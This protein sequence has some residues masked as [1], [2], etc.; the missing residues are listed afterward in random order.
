MKRLAP[1][2][3]AALVALAGCD[4]TGPETPTA[5]GNVAPWPT[6]QGLVTIALILERSQPH[7]DGQVQGTFRLDSAAGTR[8][9]PFTWDTRDAPIET[10]GDQRFH[11]VDPIACDPAEGPVTV[12]VEMG[13]WI[14]RDADVAE[15]DAYSL[16][17]TETQTV[18][19]HAGFEQLA[20]FRC[21]VDDPRVWGQVLARVSLAASTDIDEAT[22]AVWPDGGLDRSHY[23]VQLVTLTRDDAG[24]L[25]ATLAPSRCKHDELVAWSAA[26][27][28][29]TP[30]ASAAIADAAFPYR[31]VHAEA[32]CVPGAPTP[33]DLVLTP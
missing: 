19:C 4:S 3:A 32:D 20:S 16:L 9:V 1:L 10:R 18:P 5:T 26:L 24:A 14:P 33:L 6:D 15:A 30:G 7:V 2:A 22:V 23:A 8:R 28:D 29:V 27:V 31:E 25:T 11:V 12:T 13:R 17:G 21:G